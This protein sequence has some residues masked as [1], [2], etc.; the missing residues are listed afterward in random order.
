MPEI[1][2]ARAEC[3][4][5]FTFS[6]VTYRLATRGFTRSNASYDPVLVDPLVL[7]TAFSENGILM[8]RRFQLEIVAEPGSTYRTLVQNNSLAGTPITIEVVTTVT[9]TDGST[10]EQAFTQVLSIGGDALR[11]GR[12]VLD[13]VDLED[14]RLNASYPTALLT[15]DEFPKADPDGV[16][17]PIPFPVGTALKLPGRLLAQQLAWD[18]TKKVAEWIY[19]LCELEWQSYP[20]TAV[21]TG[22]KQFTVGSDI[23]P[24][25]NVG[26]A[27]W[28]FDPASRSNS[29]NAGK[30][31][32]GSISYSAPNTTIT[33]NETIGSATVSSS[34]NIPPRVLAVYRDGRLLTSTEYTVEVLDNLAGPVPAA[35][36]DF[37]NASA[38]WSAISSGTGM[39]SV[40]AGVANLSGDGGQTNYGWVRLSA[41]GIG[42][43]VSVRRHQYT[44]QRVTVTGSGSVWMHSTSATPTPVAGNG[45]LIA[46][47]APTRALVRNANGTADL[48]VSFAT[49]GTGVAASVTLDNW[50]IE[51]PAKPQLLLRFYQE[52]R[53]PGGRLYTIEADVLGYRSRNV[54]DEIK[55]LLVAAGA[56]AGAASFGAAATIAT[57]NVMLVDCDYGARGQRKFR[58]ILEDLLFFARGALVRGSTGDYDIVQDTSASNVGTLD[59]L[60]GDLIEVQGVQR[61]PRV[62][63]KAVQ[64]RPS[65][66]NPNEL[67]HTITRT[68]SGGILGAESPRP[69]PYVRDHEAAD[70]F[71]C[72]LANRAAANGKMSGRVLLA[73]PALGVVYTISSAP[74]YASTK[75]WFLWNLRHELNGVTFD[76][77]EYSSAVHTYTPNPYPADADP[78]Y[79]P[80]YSQTPPAAPTALKI[81]AAAAVIAND[82]D[83]T[84]RITCE[85]VPPAELGRAVVRGHP[86]R[87]ERSDARSRRLR[88]GEQQGYVE[89]RRAATRR[90]VQAHRVRR[91]RLRRAGHGAGHV[92]RHGHRRWRRGDHVHHAGRDSR[93]VERGQLQ[94]QPGHGPH[95]ERVVAR[96]E[97][98]QPVGLRARARRGRRLLRSVPR[99][100]HELPRHGREH[101][102]GIHLPREG[103][104]YLRQ[105]ERQLRHQRLG[106]PERKHPGRNERQRHRLVDGSHGQPNRHHHHF[107]G[108]GQPGRL[109]GGRGHFALARQG[110][111]SRRRAD[112]QRE[113]ER[114]HERREQLEHHVP[115]VPRARPCHHVGGTEQPAQPQPH[116]AEHERHVLGRPLVTP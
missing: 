38:E 72:Y 59:E 69:L 108:V 70:R 26:D 28:V 35:N 12:V 44:M 89:H 109:D 87:D 41:A 76:A 19:A 54:S 75:D 98:Q 32:I 27:V 50:Q 3:Y 56:S 102:H 45:T 22:A 113:R 18:G 95:R 88:R 96:G 93:A 97:R 94:R 23:R 90:G 49:F 52:Q 57:N 42:A 51:Q 80:D 110:A 73:R 112:G 13:V 60:Q 67:Q 36:S 1:A 16:G 84:A 14:E 63:S 30:Y 82:G 48:R 7:T 62:L 15:A 24:Q 55:R 92:R 106:E 91:E 20:I 101:R 99:A 105:R 115:R 65:A 25:V 79:T 47:G 8:G 66:R 40:A 29:T 9:Y 100:G 61:P 34:I 78:G 116:L 6:A 53:D 68:V 114:G 31:T 46:A 10:A 37:S 81:T 2:S 58:A 103:A 5:T 33:V 17:K 86:Q 11:P 83:T 104:R 111:S 74:T 64:Y 43:S 21:S 71:L 39:A 77:L 107:G 4:A 85:C